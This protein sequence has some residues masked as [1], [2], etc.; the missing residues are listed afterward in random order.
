MAGGCAD[1]FWRLPDRARAW[2]GR[3]GRRLRGRGDCPRPPRGAQDAARGALGGGE[4]RG[5]LPSRGADRGAAQPSEHRNRLRHRGRKRDTLH[6]HG[7]RQGTDAR[8]T[9]RAASAAARRRFARLGHEGAHRALSGLRALGARRSRRRARAS[10][11]ELLR[12]GRRRSS[13]DGFATRDDFLGSRRAGDDSSES[14]RR[15]PR[16]RGPGLGVR[17]SHGEGLR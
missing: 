2:P 12:Y 13:K 4:D 7:A 3:H 8:E 15:P 1:H 16:H 17:H 11:I 5:A 6:C 9:A 10:G 14:R